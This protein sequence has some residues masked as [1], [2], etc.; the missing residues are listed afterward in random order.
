MSASTAAGGYAKGRAT[1]GEIVEVATGLFGEV[2]YRAASLRAVAARCGLTHPGVMHHFPTK[3]ALL[4]AVLE[5]RDAADA[6]KYLPGA[7]SGM[8]QLRRLIA[9]VEHNVE[10]PQIVEL[11]AALSAEAADPAHPAHDW[12]VRRYTDTRRQFTDVLDRV[13]ADGDLVP[14]VEPRTA[15]VALAALMDGLQVQWLL[16]RETIDMVAVLR[17]HVGRLVT[18]PL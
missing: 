4:A 16:D 8:E 6:E 3:A 2:G 1:R 7:G 12:F 17:D 13:R 11:H 18:V 5:R 10:V 14:G 15:A 9:L